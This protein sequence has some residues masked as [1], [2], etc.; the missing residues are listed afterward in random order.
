[1]RFR[2]K[3]VDIVRCPSRR[4]FFLK[5]CTCET[6]YFRGKYSRKN[7]KTLR[8]NSKNSR[9]T[10]SIWLVLRTL[11]IIHLS[12][13]LDGIDTRRLS[14]CARV[15]KGLAQEPAASRIQLV[16]AF[17]RQCRARKIIRSSCGDTCLEM[18]N[19]NSK[20]LSPFA[21]LHGLP[22]QTFRYACMDREWMRGGCA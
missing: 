10:L 5:G 11:Q 2:L 7:A 20:P 3:L 15:F 9:T 8:R 19:S 13:Q 17:F 12:S 6:K 18:C 16:L 4:F 1:M 14:Q 21:R 22:T